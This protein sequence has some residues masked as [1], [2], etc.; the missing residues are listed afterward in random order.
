[1]AQLLT[2]PLADKRLQLWF[3]DQ[4]GK[5]TSRSQTNPLPD[6]P[7]TAWADF[8]S[9]PMTGFKSI[10]AGSLPQDQRLQLWAIDDM[11]KIWS[12]SQV[13]TDT[14]AGWTDW[15]TFSAPAAV[16][17]LEGIGAASLEDGWLQ[18]WIVQALSEVWMIRMISQNIS[19]GWTNWT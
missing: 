7:W 2:A 17:N 8:P 16:G 4:F 3:L 18:V 14:G 12:A 15:A 19:A 6:A 1:M 10:A 11:D 9:P 5:L 13:S